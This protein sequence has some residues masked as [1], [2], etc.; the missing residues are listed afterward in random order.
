MTNVQIIEQA[1][2]K[3]I[4]D[5]KIK[6]DD[7]IHTYKHWKKLGYQV[8]RGEKAVASLNI[9]QYFQKNQADD[10]EEQKQPDGKMRMRRAYFFSSEQVFSIE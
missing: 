1:K 2:V 5:G 8:L 7:E 4:A 10:D 6:P 9:W 3:L